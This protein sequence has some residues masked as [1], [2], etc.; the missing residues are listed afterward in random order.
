MPDD[1]IRFRREDRLAQGLIQNTMKHRLA[2]TNRLLLTSAAICLFGG[3]RANTDRS[4]QQH[5]VTIADQVYP[6]VFEVEDLP[7]SV[8]RTIADDLE[9]NFSSNTTATLR[10]ISPERREQWRGRTVTHRLADFRS[11]KFYRWSSR[12]FPPIIRGH[13]RDA[14]MVNDEFHLIIRDALIKAYEEKLE[15]RNQHPGM[16]REMDDFLATLKNP[17]K[18]KAIARD[19]EQAKKFVYCYKVSFDRGLSL[20]RSLLRWYSRYVSSAHDV[21]IRGPSLLDIVSLSEAFEDADAP[22]GVYVLAALITV[23]KDGGDELSDKLPLAAYADG[24]WHFFAW[25]VP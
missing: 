12:Q 5:T 18:L 2:A 16:F 14:V 1:G 10:V 24:R 17:S 8:K 11:G 21:K 25:P 3:C 19:A 6:L 22:E 4:G 9:L 7:N 13:F 15:L 20:L 23:R